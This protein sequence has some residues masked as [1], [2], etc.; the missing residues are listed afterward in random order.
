MPALWYGEKDFGY[1][2]PIEGI[3][4]RRDHV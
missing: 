1:L 2:L 3:R 4:Y